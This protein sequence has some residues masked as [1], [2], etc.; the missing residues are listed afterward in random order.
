[1]YPNKR[2][3]LE[4]ISD[5]FIIWDV[6]MKSCNL[7]VSVLHV[8]TIVIKNAIFYWNMQNCCRWLDVMD[9]LDRI[10]IL[11]APIRQFNYKRTFS[12]LKRQVQHGAKLIG[13]AWNY[14]DAKK[15]AESHHQSWVGRLAGGC[16]EN[17]LQTE[18]KEQREGTCQ[19]HAKQTR[20]ISHSWKWKRKKE[21]D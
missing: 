18:K 15:L 20:V 1:M 4:R 13:T 6:I 7:R 14:G 2:H 21:N 10:E 12:S 5:Y 9:L 3:V 16:V 17:E 11:T 8:V 19:V